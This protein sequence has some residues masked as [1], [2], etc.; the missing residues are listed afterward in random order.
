MGS[1]YG[2]EDSGCTLPA[3]VAIAENNENKRAKLYVNKKIG[4]A[5]GVDLSIF[6]KLR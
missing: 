5:M 6:P 1:R 2:L 4:A 3:K